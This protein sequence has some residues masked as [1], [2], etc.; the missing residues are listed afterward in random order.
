MRGERGSVSVV[1]A[2]TIAVIAA[3][4][5][6][7]ADLA[8]ALVAVERADTAADAAA[9]AAAQEIALPTGRPPADVASEYAQRNG[10]RLTECRCEAG[11]NEAVVT[12]EL[13]VGPMLIVPGHRTVSAQA[14]A[15]VGDNGA[16]A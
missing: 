2:A 10:G 14:R 15:V 13:D 11:A 4:T 3:L 1:A 16:G 8:R 9:L 5:M 12:V 7:C 6:G